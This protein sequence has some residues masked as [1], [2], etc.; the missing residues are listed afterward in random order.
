MCITYAI[1]LVYVVIR[2]IVTIIEGRI[3]KFMLT[4]PLKTGGFI[5]FYFIFLY[6]RLDIDEL[7]SSRD[8]SSKSIQVNHMNI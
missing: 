2:I 5:Y 3:I 8:I 1:A 7:S 6:I 4:L